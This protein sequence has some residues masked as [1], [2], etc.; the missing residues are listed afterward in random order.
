MEILEPMQGSHSDNV[1]IEQ[2]SN[3]TVGAIQTF[4]P[5]LLAAGSAVVK[6]VNLTSFGCNPIAEVFSNL[7]IGIFG[8]L[9]IR[10]R[11]TEEQ[12]IAVM[13]FGKSYC[14]EGLLL[15]ATAYQLLEGHIPQELLNQLVLFPSE[16]LMTGLVTEETSNAVTITNTDMPDRDS[17]GNKIPLPML[18]GDPRVLKQVLMLSTVK[19]I[20]SAVTI[21]F[22]LYYNIPVLSSIGLYFGSNAAGSLIMCLVE[23]LRD[24]ERR[25]LS[26]EEGFAKP[27]L[28]LILTNA[29]IKITQVIHPILIAIAN[30]IAPQFYPKG[31]VQKIQPDVIFTGALVGAVNSSSRKN[32]QEEYSTEKP[33]N[34]REESV[35]LLEGD[36]QIVEEEEIPEISHSSSPSL[37]GRI[38]KKMGE[39]LSGLVGKMKNYMRQRGWEL[40]AVIAFAAASVAFF[41]L[42]YIFNDDNRDRISTSGY[43]GGG[44]AGYT[45]THLVSSFLDPR[46]ENPSPQRKESKSLIV[47]G[48][49]TVARAAG[50]SAFF[51]LCR[52]LIYAVLPYLLTVSLQANLDNSGKNNIDNTDWKSYATQLLGQ[53]FLGYSWGSN[54]VFQDRLNRPRIAVIPLL[55]VSLITLTAVLHALGQF[56]DDSH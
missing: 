23:K 1:T 30:G 45:I 28:F 41:I 17:L 3:R 18:Q 32:F 36:V 34:I 14:Q 33:E 43:L 8:S 29:A 42:L 24:R 35:S 56:S 40:F 44:L 22:G 7:G 54:R 55:A 5:A 20:I 53:I 38:T 15:G 31:I 47:R 12:R 39:K 6:T 4:A 49:T 19:A 48:C 27:S 16:T 50:N 52:N 11:L 26:R 51:Y 10:D 21:F 9:F 46:K 13:N 25:L 2:P 37:V